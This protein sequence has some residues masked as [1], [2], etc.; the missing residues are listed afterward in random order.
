MFMKK[1]QVIFFST[2]AVLISGYTISA[3]IMCG[4]FKS[5]QVGFIALCLLAYALVHLSIKEY[6][7]SKF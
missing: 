1:L 2:L 3:I 4:E 5:W 6:K 7:Q